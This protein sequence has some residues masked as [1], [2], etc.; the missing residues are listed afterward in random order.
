MYIYEHG[1]ADFSEGERES[2]ATR[3]EP[4]LSY[5]RERERTM[6]LARR[7]KKS[8]MTARRLLIIRR[9][10]RVELRA[11]GHTARAFFLELRSV[12]EGN[13]CCRRRC[14]FVSAGFFLLRRGFNASSL[15]LCTAASSLCGLAR[16]YTRGEVI[17]VRR[18]FFGFYAFVNTERT[19]LVSDVGFF[20][21]TLDSGRSLRGRVVDYI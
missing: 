18:A 1:A 13:L 21:S 19:T 4:V 20:L 3:R 11:W 2:D 15:L 9:Y 10:I 16:V 8:L 17:F 5:T 6:S 12:A 14:I 7:P